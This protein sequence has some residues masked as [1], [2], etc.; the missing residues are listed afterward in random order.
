VALHSRRDFGRIK[1]QVLEG[2]RM[3][4][5]LNHALLKKYKPRFFFSVFGETHAAGH[6]FWRF[7]DAKHPGHVSRHGLE[8]ALLDTYKAIDGAIGEMIEQLPDDAI[9]VVL[10]SQGFSRDTMMGEELLAEVLVRMGL[11]VPR[12][13]HLNY[14]YAPYAPDLSLDMSRTRVFCLP[15]DLQGYLRINLRGREPQGIVG[16]DEYNSLC[17]ELESELLALRDCTHKTPVVDRVL[18][19]RDLYSNDQ[20]SALPDLSIIWN[21]DHLVTGLES[22][23]LGVVRREPDLTTGGGNHRGPGFIGVCGRGIAPGRLTGHVFD[24]APT[25]SRLLG[26]ASCEY[27]EG[28]LLPIPGLKLEPDWDPGQRGGAPA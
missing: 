9:L 18:R 17:D 7:Q 22:A 2:V 28:K 24:I 15:T 23:R 19:L 8:S 4:Q 11:S 3:K 20:G 13:A 21:N 27:R 16:D 5:R 6:A 26:E 25:V 1:D 10:S 12:N 14:A